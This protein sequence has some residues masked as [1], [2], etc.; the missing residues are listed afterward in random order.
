VSRNGFLLPTRAEAI[1]RLRRAAEGFGGPILLTGEPGSGKTWLVDRWTQNGST[2]SEWAKVDLSPGMAISTFYQAIARELKLKRSTDWGDLRARIADRLRES[3]DEGRSIG[4]VVDEAQLVSEDLA[5]EIRILTNRSGKDDGFAAVLI[6]GQTAL[7]RRVRQASFASLYERL[8]DRVKLGAVDFDEAR[9]FL[10]YSFPEYDWRRDEIDALHRESGGNPRRLFR[11]ALV[12][13]SLS[14]KNRSGRGETKAPLRVEK[15]QKNN[16]SKPRFINEESLPH[17]SNSVDDSFVSFAGDGSMGAFSDGPLLG[18][19]APP[20]REEEGLIEVGWNEQ[21][22]EFEGDI[23]PGRTD[24][25]IGSDSDAIDRA[26]AGSASVRDSDRFYSALETTE[27]SPSGVEAVDDH[28]AALQAWNEWARVQGRFALDR[29]G[30]S[31]SGEV[32]ASVGG[33]SGET[34]PDPFVDEESPVLPHHVRLDSE[35][36]IV[37]PSRLFSGLRDSGRPS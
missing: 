12:R 7:A 3:T 6:L 1:D 33:E 11:L 2:I 4:L 22:L 21:D 17:I 23:K 29:G 13:A 5:E 26:R 20:L 14:A 32:R 37:P 34:N 31:Q 8:V 36:A 30:I 10:A 25:G 9:M 27:E 28:Y 16:T 15:E 18:P 35:H 19:I 24:F